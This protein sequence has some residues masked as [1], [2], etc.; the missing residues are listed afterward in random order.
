[1]SNFPYCVDTVG[2]TE[3]GPSGLLKN[4]LQ[5]FSLG[6]VALTEITAAKKAIKAKV[7][8]VGIF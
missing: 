7:K 8:V 3:G 5:L 6:N 2:W 4:L 1:V